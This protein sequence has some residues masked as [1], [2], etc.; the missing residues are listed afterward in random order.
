MKFSMELARSTPS[1]S[2]VPGSEPHSAAPA[3]AS[4]AAQQ[5]ASQAVV[6]P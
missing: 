3:C 1:V 6:P 5:R 2:G 4:K